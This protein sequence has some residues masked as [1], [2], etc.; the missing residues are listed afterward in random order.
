M[1]FIRRNLPLGTCP[2]LSHWLTGKLPALPGG[3]LGGGLEYPEDPVGLGQQGAVHHRETGSHAK[4][5]KYNFYLIIYVDLWNIDI[6][7]SNFHDGG[8]DALLKKS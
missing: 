7:S 6:I 5:K 4:P 2:S 3:R 8:G 1:S